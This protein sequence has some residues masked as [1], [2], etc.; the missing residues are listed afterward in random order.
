M[1]GRYGQDALSGALNRAA[2]VLI[3]VALFFPHELLSLLALAC[4]FWS[5]FRGFSKKIEK[6]QAELAAYQRV[7]ERPRAALAKLRRRRADRRTHRY[8]K[9]ACGATL[10]VPRG[11][12]RVELTCPKCR[13][14]MTRKT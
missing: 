6:R 7:M 1:Q 10:R 4:L 8:F 12:G 2:L 14:K 5:L 9:C 11:Q 3:A 13:A